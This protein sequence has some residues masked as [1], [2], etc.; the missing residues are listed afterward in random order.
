MIEVKKSQRSVVRI[1]FDGRVYKH[2]R[3]PNAIQRMENEVTALR[4]L[5]CVGCD[6]VPRLLARDRK[7]M[8]LEMTQCG[9]PVQTIC[10]NK[11]DE[12]FAELQRYGVLHGDQHPRNI[13]YRPQDARFCVIDFEFSKIITDSVELSMDR[14]LAIV[15][16]GIGELDQS[17]NL[18][19]PF[20]A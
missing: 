19:G 11:C 13:T 9:H 2:F 16:S 8:C 4:F 20:D 15:Q 18:L 10:Q 5:E 1:S 12:L 7:R 3:G 17:L 14:C 6:F